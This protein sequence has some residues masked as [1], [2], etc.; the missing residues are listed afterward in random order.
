MYIDKETYEIKKQVL[1]YLQS[2]VFD[3]GTPDEKVARPRMEV[4]YTP[5]NTSPVIDKD[6]FK[7]SNYVVTENN[8]TIGA[9]TLA[10]Y[11]LTNL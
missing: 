10:D 4:T 2:A 3:K 7:L 1:Y 8:I 11:I 9:G 6:I 5:V